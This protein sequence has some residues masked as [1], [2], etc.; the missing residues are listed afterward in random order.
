MWLAERRK[1]VG[2]SQEKLADL[3]GIARSSVSHWE[4]GKFNPPLD[5]PQFRRD[6][7][8]A[9]KMTIPELLTLAGYEID[10]HYSR[11]AMRAADLVEQLPSEQRHLALGILEQLL[12]ANVAQV[13]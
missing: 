12:N 2:L 13:G 9:L 4:I 11:E 8:N 7:A 5:D 1:A 3:L 10:R 6:L